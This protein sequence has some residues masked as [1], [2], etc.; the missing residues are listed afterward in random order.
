MESQV[1]NTRIYTLYVYLINYY[2]GCRIPAR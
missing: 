2:R 1:N